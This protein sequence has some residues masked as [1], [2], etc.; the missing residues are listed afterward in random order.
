MR[1]T[2]CVDDAKVR[3]VVYSHC[4]SPFHRLWSDV[5]VHM[6]MPPCRLSKYRN[7][8]DT[9]CCMHILL[10]KSGAGDPNFCFVFPW[11]TDFSIHTKGEEKRP[12]SARAGSDNHHEGDEVPLSASFSTL[13][14]NLRDLTQSKFRL[15]K[16]D[17]QLDLTYRCGS[18]SS[19]DDGRDAT[20]IN[21]MQTIV[22]AQE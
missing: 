19:G 12:Q 15:T 8:K 1:S 20:G 2:A 3:M 14:L 13:T 16:G 5:I 6:W 11:V 9:F 4:L 10:A 17:A 18:Q 22:L 21:R 7:K